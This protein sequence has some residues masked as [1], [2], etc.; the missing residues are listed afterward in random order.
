[1]SIINYNKKLTNLQLK[2]FNYLAEEHN[3][4][5]EFFISVLF[6]ILERILKVVDLIQD[7]LIV[8]IFK[9]LSFFIVLILLLFNLVASIPTIHR[10]STTAIVTTTE[11]TVNYPVAIID[12]NTNIIAISINNIPPPLLRLEEKSKPL[13]LEEKKKPL[14]LEEKP[15]LLLPFKTVEVEE[16]AIDEIENIINPYVREAVKKKREQLQIIDN[17]KGTLIDLDKIKNCAVD[18]TIPNNS[19]PI[20]FYCGNRFCPTC[21]QIKA[22]KNAD[23]LK[24]VLTKARENKKVLLYGTFTTKNVE[25]TELTAEINKIN[26]AFTKTL[27]VPKKLKDNIVGYV[28]KLEIKFNEARN[29]YNVHI[30]T[31]IAVSNYHK[32]HITVEEF[33]Q[34]FKRYTK[35]NDIIPPD[36]RKIGNED[37]DITKVA[38]Y[39]VKEDLIQNMSFSN[40]VSDNIYNAVKN[41]RLLEF[42]LSFKELKKEAENTLTINKVSIKKNKMPILTTLTWND[43][44]K[45]YIS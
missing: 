15:L 38:N 34:H 5:F 45:I 36:I 33:Y 1:M 39:I 14:L 32:N 2:L 28:K 27:T 29:D 35:D 23:I 20:T 3:P 9:M 18:L 10:P 44:K 42:C 13:L 22:G 16:K 12:K 43:K 21:S 37:K 30:H 11:K 25:A 17:F 19:K 7:I 41:K 4:A 24:K 26:T 40:E 6:F 31:V 8:P